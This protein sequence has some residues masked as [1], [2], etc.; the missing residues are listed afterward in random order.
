MMMDRGGSQSGEGRARVAVVG[1]GIAGLTVARRLAARGD[2]DLTVWDAARRA[3]GVIQTSTS[4]DGFVREHAANAFLISA[5]DG[6]APLAEE[7]GLEIEPASPAARKR[8]VWRGGTLRG[9]PGSPA[10]IAR[11]ELLS[12]RGLLRALGE[13]LVPPRSDGVEETVAEFFRRRLGQ[14]VVSALVAPLCTGIYAG[15]PELLS[16]P[17]AFPRLARLEAEGG[18]LRGGLAQ[19]FRRLRARGDAGGGAGGSAARPRRRGLAAPVGGMA[20]LTARLARE[21]SGRL[22]LG[23]A[24]VAVEVEGG[25]RGRAVRLA[26]GRREPFDAVVLATPAPVTARLLS[27]ASRDAAAALDGIRFAPAQVVHLGYRRG[28]VNHPADGFGFLVGPGEDLRILGAVLESVIWPSRAPADHLLIRCILGGQRDPGAAAL[29]DDELVEVC[30]RDLE[31]ALAIAG[32]PVHR[33]V[34]RHDRA[35]AQYTIGHGGRVARAEEL[36]LPMGV[37]L[38]GSSYHGVSV[39]GCVADAARVEHRVASRLGLP[40]LAVLVV[41]AGGGAGVNAGCSGGARPAAGPARCTMTAEAPRLRGRPRPGRIRRR[42]DRISRPGR[43][44]TGPGI[45]IATATSSA[46]GRCRW[47]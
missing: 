47:R 28:D 4:D 7:L 20:A 26:D 24:A 36:A 43:R 14:E 15:D 2:I 18:L 23:V 21:L 42:A 5:Q 35:I 19:A 12:W 11:G 39:N 40:L 17:A 16:L 44:P 32:P 6:A 31:R 10:A 1:A 9:L 22:E 3:G 27:D 25:G 33:H 45:W 46:G 30:H 29:S 41:L 34:V 37:V 38:A 8:W 13:P